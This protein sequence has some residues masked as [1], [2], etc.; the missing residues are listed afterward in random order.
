MWK[1]R[2]GIWGGL[3]S[4]PE[5]K[6]ELNIEQWIFKNIGS[7]DFKLIQ[8]GIMTTTFTHYKLQMN[9]QHLEVKKLTSSKVME[10]LLW[11]DKDN[12]EEGAYP[13]PVKKLVQ[14]LLIGKI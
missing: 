13:A 6:K 10:G 11:E 5:F 2:K 4:F 7:N 14:K 3:W 9:Y 1:P 12:I 8:N